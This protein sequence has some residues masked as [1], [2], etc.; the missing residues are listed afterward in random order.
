[1]NEEI[2]N[3]RDRTRHNSKHIK[4]KGGERQRWNLI[5]TL[6]DLE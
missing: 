2:K 3:K 6:N 5:D 4:V 1:M